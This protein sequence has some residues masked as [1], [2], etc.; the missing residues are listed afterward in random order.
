MQCPS[1]FPDRSYTKHLYHQDD[2]LT[3]GF[4]VLVLAKI[5]SHPFYIGPS[6]LMDWRDQ[7]EEDKSFDGEGG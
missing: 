4:T 6:L 3:S 1:V 5:E 2:D 7:D